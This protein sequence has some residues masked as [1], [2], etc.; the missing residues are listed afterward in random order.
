MCVEISAK[1]RSNIDML[2]ETILIKAETMELKAKKTG[3]ARGVVL[4]TFQTK[5]KGMFATAIVNSGT[6]KF[7]DILVFENGMVRRKEKSSDERRQVADNVDDVW[8]K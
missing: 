1:K 2:L 8:G 5:G 4:D 7:G 3:I 6:L